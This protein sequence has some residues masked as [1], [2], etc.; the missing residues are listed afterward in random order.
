[1]ILSGNN[2][3]VEAYAAHILDVVN[4]YNW[5]YKLVQDAKAGKS[6]PSRTSQQRLMA[7]QVLQGQLL[8]SRDRFFFPPD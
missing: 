5:R 4:H 6:H 1:V 2:A 8:A 7:G 3:V